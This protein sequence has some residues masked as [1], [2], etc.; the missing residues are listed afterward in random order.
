MNNGDALQTEYEFTL[1]SGYV[2]KNG[3]E[4]KIH[5][6][7]LM[8]LATAADEIHPFKD[9]RVQNNQPYLIIVLLA[10]V[11]TKLGTLKSVDTDVIEKMHVKDLAYLQ[12]LYNRVNHNISTAIEAICP[13]CAHR[14]QVEV[15]SA[16]GL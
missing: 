9:P 7:G 10:R 3:E 13:K 12:D 2:E 6:E 14:F 16:G 4:M 5:R 8:R 11:I 15:D 1:P